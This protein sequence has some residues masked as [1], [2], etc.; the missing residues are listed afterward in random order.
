MAQNRGAGAPRVNL[1][2]C[3]GVCGRDVAIFALTKN[4]VPG[5]RAWND[6]SI[7]DLATCSVA[8][9][10]KWRQPVGA[11]HRPLGGE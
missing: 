8:D 9:R 1:V 5:E 11:V 10:A 3:R 6:V 2:A 7:A 4:G